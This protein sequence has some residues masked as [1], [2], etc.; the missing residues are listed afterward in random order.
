MHHF[1]KL[2]AGLRSAAKETSDSWK[3]SQSVQ[4]ITILCAEV[5]IIIK[6]NMSW[7]KLPAGGGGHSQLTQEEVDRDESAHTPIG[8]NAPEVS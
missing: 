8:G 7:Q 6:R 2:R 1:I 4:E 3:V 5:A